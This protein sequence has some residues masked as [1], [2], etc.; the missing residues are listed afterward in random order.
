MPYCTRKPRMGEMG[1]RGACQVAWNIG[2]SSWVNIS[3]RLRGALN[4]AFN[5][6]LKDVTAMN[7]HWQLTTYN[8]HY[9]HHHTKTIL[10]PLFWDHQGEPGEPLDFMVQGKIN[11]GRHRDHPAGCHSIRTNQCPP[12][13][14]PHFLQ[15]WCPSCHP[16]NSVKALKET[17]AFELTRIC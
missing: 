13:P 1:L 2:G 17:S 3:C 16:T 11:R 10:P 4:T 5:T 9:H 15:A 7:S 12:P 8:G 6:L 14:C